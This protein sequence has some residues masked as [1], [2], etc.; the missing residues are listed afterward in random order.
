MKI[1]QTSLLVVGWL[2]LLGVSILGLT[3]TEYT[4]TERLAQLIYQVD[5]PQG[6]VLLRNVTTENMWF[7][8]FNDCQIPLTANTVAEVNGTKMVVDFRQTMGTSLAHTIV[9]DITNLK[10]FKMDVPCMEGIRSLDFKFKD[11]WTEIQ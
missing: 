8:S 4:K 7:V 2:V 1:V 11:H 10:S 6:K 9:R 3:H 5:T